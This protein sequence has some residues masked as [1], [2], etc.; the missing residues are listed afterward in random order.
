[1]LNAAL[2]EIPYRVAAPLINS[3]NAQIQKQFDRDENAVSGSNNNIPRSD[4]SPN[5]L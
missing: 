4:D 5:N 1:M 2:S 3:I